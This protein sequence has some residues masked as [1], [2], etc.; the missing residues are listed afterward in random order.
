LPKQSSK[1]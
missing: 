1:G